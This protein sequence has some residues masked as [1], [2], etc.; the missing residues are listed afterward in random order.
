MEGVDYFE[1]YIA[2]VQWTTVRL[3]LMLEVIVDLKS[4]QGDVTAGFLRA[5][6]NKGEKVYVVMPQGF[7][8]KGKI[9]SLN[10]TMCG[11]KQLLRAFWQYIV[12]KME[13]CEMKQ[14]NLDPCLYV[15]EEVVSVVFVD[16]ILFCAK[17][18]KDIHDLAL[19]LHELGVDM[20]QEED[21][22]GF[23]GVGIE[24]NE[25]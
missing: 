2:A 7:S 22:A 11:L 5:E 1:M 24:K 4:E 17:D 14:S 20:E 8:Q 6:L 16:D 13:S 15:G 12:Q 3:M 19:N 25:D 9:L 18:E 23:L 21:E 10:C